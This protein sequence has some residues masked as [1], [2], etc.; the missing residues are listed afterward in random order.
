M[1]LYATHF[2]T[3]KGETVVPEVGMGSDDPLYTSLYV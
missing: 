1:P 2:D 3:L